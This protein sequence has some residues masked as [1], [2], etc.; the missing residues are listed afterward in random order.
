MRAALTVGS[1]HSHK[2]SSEVAAA[3]PRFSDKCKDQGSRRVV[4]QTW[5]HFLSCL[6]EEATP[7][8]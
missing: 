1:M 7:L 3:R 6:V 2:Q 8:G 5:S 4:Q